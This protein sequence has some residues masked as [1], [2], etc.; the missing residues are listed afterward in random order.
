MWCGRRSGSCSPDRAGLKPD[1]DVVLVLLFL[2]PLDVGFFGLELK[3]EVPDV[4][5]HLLEGPELRRLAVVH[6]DDVHA[7]RGGDRFGNRTWRRLLD[8]LLD[9][10]E[11]VPRA[12]V[13]EAAS[14]APFGAIGI[15]GCQLLEPFAFF[16]QRI[17]LLRLLAHRQ[18]LAAGS[19]SDQDLA[20]ADFRGQHEAVPVLLVV[21]E[22]FL[23]RHQQRGLDLLADEAQ[24][25]ELVLDERHL[26]GVVLVWLLAEPAQADDGV[27]HLLL[28]DL[29]ASPLGD[30]HLELALDHPVQAHVVDLTQALGQLGLSVP[31]ADLR[32][33]VADFLLQFAQRDDL[34]VDHGHD[35]VLEAGG[36]DWESAE[37]AGPQRED[38][39]SL[40]EGARWHASVTQHYGVAATGPGAGSSEAELGTSATR[41]LALAR[42]DATNSS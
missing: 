1:L 14:A 8:R 9:L 13:P 3:H 20:D 39:E 22:Y 11:H 5:F 21:A 2:D 27:L 10:R 25:G 15:L 33:R 24:G 23:A 36:P 32:L 34:G 28:R 35:P 29:D 12:D 16:E 42:S 37:E 30:L 40:L 41:S 26:L 31:L 17:D 6:A 4:L 7:D 38:R 18:Q 19:K